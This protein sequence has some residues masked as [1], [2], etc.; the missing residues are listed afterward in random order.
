MLDVGPRLRA[1][2]WNY[3]LLLGQHRENNM[4]SSWIFWFS[5]L[6]NI[7]LFFQ[8]TNELLRHDTICESL[9]LWLTFSRLRIGYEQSEKVWLWGPRVPDKQLGGKK[10]KVIDIGGG[11]GGETNKQANKNLWGVFSVTVPDWHAFF[12]FYNNC[13]GRLFWRKFQLAFA[14]K[15]PNVYLRNTRK[16]PNL[17][18]VSMV[19]GKY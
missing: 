3:E 19:S 18:I 13:K 17:L 12:L 4:Q 10:D 5:S 14:E 8:L 15:Y 1:I 11:V 16:L 7:T 2:F 6:G 9:G